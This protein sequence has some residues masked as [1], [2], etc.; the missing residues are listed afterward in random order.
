RLVNV[1]DIETQPRK[2]RGEMTPA[3]GPGIGPKG[4]VSTTCDSRFDTRIERRGHDGSIR[5]VGMAHASDTRRVDLRKS[6]QVIDD[7]LH[8]P[9]HLAEEGPVW[10]FAIEVMGAVVGLLIFRDAL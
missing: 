9:I 8:I 3:I 10:V 6:F 4:S 7:T 1:V 2:Q 5:A